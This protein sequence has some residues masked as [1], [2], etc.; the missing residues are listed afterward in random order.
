MTPL[1]W[2]LVTIDIDGT[3]TLVH[4]WKVIADELGRA[5]EYARTKERFL[6]GEIGEDEHLRDLLEIAVGHPLAEVEA[7]LE[8][9]P[10]PA[11]IE[12]TVRELHRRG[13]KV[14]LLTHNPAYV[15]DWYRARFGFDDFEGTPNAP[16]VDGRVAPLGA[17]VAG[18]VGGLHRLLERLHLP[19]GSTVHVGDARPDAEVF[20]HVG[21]GVALNSVFPDVRK[22]ADATLDTRD[23]FD[24]IEVL[25]ALRPRPIER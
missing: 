21:G 24:L 8:K 25:E 4:G 14:A 19:A 20:P 10:R 13:A 1:P 3:L 5:R 15:G 9:T 12:E 2:K 7:A 11:R 22:A 23:L 6:S 18:K 17:I 16:V